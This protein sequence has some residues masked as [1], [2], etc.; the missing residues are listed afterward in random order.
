MPA[1]PLEAAADVDRRIREVAR[2]F[3]ALG[4]DDDAVGFRGAIA[5]TR[6]LDRPLLVQL[7]TG[8][9]VTTRPAPRGRVEI[10][11]AVGPARH[12]RFGPDVA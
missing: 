9:V 1:T 5:L 4:R 10:G 6:R 3:G 7:A 12:A 2:A 11:G 8:S